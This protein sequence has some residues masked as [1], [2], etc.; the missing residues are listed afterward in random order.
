MA[1]VS[2]LA[3]GLH[4]VHKPVGPSSRAVMDAVRGGREKLCHGGALDPFASGLLLVLAD[5]GTH[6]FPFLHAVPKVYEAEI[7]WGTETDNGDP[8]GAVVATGPTRGLS[9]GALDAALAPFRGWTEQVPPPTSNKRVGGERAYVRVHRGE[10]VELPPSRVYLHQAAWIR[11]ELPRRS[12]L[13]LSVGGGFYVRSLARD[14][15]RALG[16]RAHLGELW[17]KSIGPWA[18][19]GPGKVVALAGDAILPWCPSRALTDAERLELAVGAK[20]EPGALR[21][22]SWTCPPGF[23]EPPVRLFYAGRLVGV[24]DAGDR[25]QVRV[26][27]R[28]GV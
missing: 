27:L 2:P 14:L 12:W 16:T 11:H 23:P 9:L 8:G 21:G 1:S 3:P 20:L 5:E 4:L 24:A 26:A 25:L 10:V 19:P 17:R 6:L 13:R 7:R 22:P 18:D 15:G 28:R